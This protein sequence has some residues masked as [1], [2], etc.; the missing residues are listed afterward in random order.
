MQWCQWSWSCTQVHTVSEH[1]HEQDSSE[2]LD[3]TVL[4]HHDTDE[5][6]SSRTRSHAEYSQHYALSGTQLSLLLIVPL[7]HKANTTAPKT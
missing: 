7:T 2:W 6:A 1:E 4:H 5:D 3:K